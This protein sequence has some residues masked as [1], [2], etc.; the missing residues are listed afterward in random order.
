MKK[1]K[2]SSFSLKL[3]IKNYNLIVMKIN[4]LFRKYKLNIIT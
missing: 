4:I 2:K 3:P 1:I